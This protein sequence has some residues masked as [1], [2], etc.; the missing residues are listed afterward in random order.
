MDD[1]NTGDRQAE[2]PEQVQLE[3]GTYE[4]LRTRLLNRCKEL[5]RRLDELSQATVAMRH[6]A[7]GIRI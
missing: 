3:G 4:I 1:K 7:L 6:P 5:R 2:A